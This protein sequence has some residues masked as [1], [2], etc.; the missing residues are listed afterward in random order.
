MKYDN[1]YPLFNY[2][3]NLFKKKRN[4]NVGEIGVYKDVLS[5]ST[6]N[7]GTH[8]VYYDYFAKVRAKA[9]YDNLIEIEII[10]VDA[11]NSCNEEIKKLIDS[12]IPKYINPKYVKWEVQPKQV[13]SLTK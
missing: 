2:F 13:E 8:T 4:I 9:I 5:T 11:M 3:A 1:D 7:D 6:I 10:S 12:N